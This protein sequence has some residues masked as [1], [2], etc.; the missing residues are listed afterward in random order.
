MTP[1][2]IDLDTLLDVLAGATA[3]PDGSG[4]GAAP[5][6]LVDLDTGPGG[7]PVPE[8]HTGVARVIVG[9]TTGAALERH[10][11]AAACDVVLHRDDGPALA[12]LVDT[13]GTH[14]LAATALVLLLRGGDGRPV[15]QG[16]HA[17]SAVYSTLQAGPEFAAWRAA[18]P[19]RPRRRAGGD[20]V[21]LARHR[22]R[23]SITLSRPH[24][25]NALDT[26]MRDQLV[27]AFR[28]VALDPAITSVHLSGAGP[29][30]CAGGDLDEF[31]SFPDPVTAHLVRLRQSVGR[32][33][34]AVSDRVTAH[35]HGA[36][37]GSGIEL[38]AFAGT[39]LAHPSTTIA[40]PEIGLGLVPGAGGTVSLPRRIGR[41]RTARLALTGER[42]GVATAL[43]WGLVDA[44]ETPEP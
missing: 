42:I 39:V 25:H 44:A 30:F 41:H 23:L 11:A 26:A 6:L 19:R 35:L 14:P 1:D 20:P 18:R 16:L 21:R 43:E 8:A 12:A 17:E 38:P 9:L 15:D 7:R 33:I 4:P 13:V 37:M 29:S 27:E 24:V 2:P 40:L 36:C 34:H 32:A 31:G 3:E 5:V 10:P 22:D 28:L